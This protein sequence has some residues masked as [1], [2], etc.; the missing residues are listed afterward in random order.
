MGRDIG[1]YDLRCEAIV[2]EREQLRY[3]GRGKNGFE[4]HYIKRQCLRRAIAG[5]FCRQHQYKRP[6]PSGD[7]NTKEE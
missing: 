5:G 3:T 2:Y 1:K 6:L 7:L 4:R